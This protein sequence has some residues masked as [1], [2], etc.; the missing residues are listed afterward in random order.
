M[1]TLLTKPK[2]PDVRTR[3]PEKRVSE[4][5]LQAA[6]TSTEQVFALL[7]TS[8]KG[9]PETEVRRRRDQYGSNE[10]AHDKPQSWYAMLLANFKNPF[11]LVLVGIGALSLVPDD[12]GEVS[13]K[14]VV[15]VSVMITVSVLMRFLQEF[16][17]SKAAEHL[18]AMVRTKATVFRQYP[19]EVDGANTFASQKRETPFEDLVPGDLIQLSAGDMVPADVRLLSSKDLFVSQS[20][21]TGESMPVEKY[22]TLAAVV[23]K[24]SRGSGPVRGG[25]LERS[26]LCFL[27]T[28][29]VSGSGTAVVVATG[30][31][32]YFG[33]LAKSVLG[34]RSLTSFDKGINSVTW[35]L[36]R[37]IIVMAPL[38]FVLNGVVKG[39]WQEAFG[40]AVAVAVG[41]TPEMLP[42]VV[43]ANLAKGAVA[44]AKQKVIVK[45]LNA[46]QN[47][48]AMD[49]L[50]TDKTGTLTQD[51]IILEQHLDIH[52]RED[53]QV[54]RYAYLN[55][56]YQ[57]GLKNLLDRAVLEHV[58]LVHQLHIPEAYK[59]ID[60]IPFD[61]VRRRMSV[62]VEDFRKD[63]LLICKGAVEEMLGICQ[64][65][66]DEGK[67][68]PLT[69]DLRRHATFMK[70]E[71]N[72]DGM[73]VIAVAYR[74]FS[75]SERSFAVADERDL[76]LAGFIAFLDPPKETAAPALAALHEHGV[77]VKILTGDNEVVTRKVCKEV[78]LPVERVVLGAEIEKANDEALCDLA[79]KHVV[80]AKLT[81]M[82]KARIIKALQ[83]NG[84]TVGYLGDG[85]NDAA[86]LRDADV[87]I[88]VDAATDIARESADIIM[89][90]KSLLVLEEAVLKGR[91][92]YGNIIKYIK[93][94][95]SSNFGN[96][97]SMLAASAFLPFYPMLSIQIL[98]QNLLYDFSQLSLPWDRMDREFLKK[99]RKWDPRGIGRF[100]LF[101]GPISS[102]FDIA[103]FLVMWY[104][105]RVGLSYYTGQP[106]AA[107]QLFQSGWFVEGLLSQ[108]LIVHMIR[109]EKIPFLQSTAAMPV[110][111]LTS[112]IMALG[113]YL[114][115]SPLAE[116]LS[117]QPLPWQYFPWLIGMLLAYCGLTQGVK[118]L[119]LR[120]FKSWL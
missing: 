57:T 61:F 13:W 15:V 33:S 102:I 107:T 2:T 63:H 41:L 62:V 55:S 73:R 46:I 22:D 93:M 44:M 95:A 68:I 11:I 8:E 76:V 6:D 84:H 31:R 97:F 91:E 65:A 70:D 105:F 89:L 38:M 10:V 112:A 37:F 110:V 113:I 39:N 52:F 7:N 19:V 24:S 96:V 85:I 92:V 66:D 32:T 49:V 64:T 104:V 26:N 43:T 53:E 120:A 111:L 58:E 119:Y 40:F 51:R 72:A 82:Q 117:L 36:I 108:T 14:T 34:H 74:K 5:L 59:K 45:R 12:T 50:C 20:G 101:I 71:L 48:G 25:P 94:T 69:D 60:E 30:D 88:S 109:T 87:G 118:M 47:F 4:L 29:I 103:T 81:P 78:G 28:N 56:F 35:L 75:R 23:E 9:L 90:E 106:E 115:F 67:Q 21:L 54:L 3:T 18:R 99:P 27:G 1:A 100:M 116:F 114:P 79:E 42:M 17:S 16:R 98:V 77:A 80:F 83:R 86:A